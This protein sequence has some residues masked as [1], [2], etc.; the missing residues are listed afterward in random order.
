M[1]ML[2]IGRFLAELRTASG[3]TQEQLGEE[4]GVTNK[5]VSRWECGNYLPPAEMLQI[6]SDRYNVSI[7]ELLAGQRL[8]EYCYREKAE[9]NIK[10]V[11]KESA[12]NYRERLAYFEKKWKKDHIAEDIAVGVILLAAELAALFLK[13]ALTFLPMIAIAAYSIIRYNRMRGYAEK[14]AYMV[15][16]RLNDKQ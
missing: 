5:T 6:L 1:D 9:E 8:D 3:L 2:K 7:N 15:D 4:I 14:K 10:A 13:P 16:E 12:F 11:L